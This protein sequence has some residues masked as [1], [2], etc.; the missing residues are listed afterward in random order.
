MRRALLPLLP[1]AAI[2]LAPPACRF[3]YEAVPG[4]GSD[5][6]T[7]GD[8]G[9]TNSGVGGATANG[10][11]SSSAGFPAGGTTDG[12]AGA[13]DGMAGDTSA[14]TGGDS[15]TGGSTNAGGTSGSTS[16]GGMNTGGSSNAGGSTSAGGAGASGRGG[17]SAGGSAS[18]TG[19]GSGRA[20][21]N[22][23]GGRAGTSGSGGTSGRAGT[24]GSAGLGGASGSA[25]VGGGG[26]A[27]AGGA[28]GPSLVVTTQTDESDSGATPASPGSSGFSL[29]EAITYANGL[30]NHP[31]IT[32]ASGVTTIAL[33]SPL[34]VVQQAM[35][36]QGSVALD[37]SQNTSTSACLS[38]SASN[39][40]VDSVEIH[41]CRGEPVLFSSDAS[42]GNQVSNC[43]LH[44]N[45]KALVVHGSGPTVFF[46]YVSFSAAAGVEIYATSAQVLANELVNSTSS[47]FIIHDGANS[48]FIYANLSV[49]GSTS[50]TVGAVGGVTA[51]HNTLAGASGSA[52][53]LGTATTVDARNNIFSGA[54]G[55]GIV[56][57]SSQ[58]SKLDY[59]LFFSDASGNCSGCTPGTHSVFA[60]PLYNN[61]GSLDYSLKTG[62]AAIDA[63]VDLGEDRNLGNPGNYNGSAPDL[64]FIEAG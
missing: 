48:V 30:S 11:A 44:N 60:D 2:V 19:G 3:G 17:S 20:G 31:V 55:Y 12:L 36:I 8:A 25:G 45:K 40:L 32:F 53:D 9:D 54:G 1:L 59:D 23:A 34:P 33:K 5:G 56:G 47:N 42:T 24:S 16:S 4:S 58:F 22:G 29:R 64:G 41:D 21:A 62:S 49:G 61:T 43:Y 50:V 13:T 6:V 7:V 27:G 51:W 63:G 28:T 38:V 35:N 57:T 39:V 14:A 10:G 26:T 15:A 18:G 52:L 37:A 46:N